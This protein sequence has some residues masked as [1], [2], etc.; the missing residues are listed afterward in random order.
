MLN[1]IL[2][3]QEKNP[4]TDL[5]KILEELGV[6]WFKEGY[7][8]SAILFEKIDWKNIKLQSTSTAKK[9]L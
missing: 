7:C 3:K 8:A 5:P 4:S 9:L 6:G 2:A 1:A